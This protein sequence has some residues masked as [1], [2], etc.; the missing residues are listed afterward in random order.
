VR[1][2][3]S[4][5][6]LIGGT[7]IVLLRNVI[8]KL[9]GE[10]WAKCEFMNPSG[11]VKDRIA[12]YMIRNAEKKGLIKPGMKFL[13][14]TTGNTGIAFASVGAYLGYKVVIVI[15]E[16]MSSER[17]LTLKAL[18]AEIIY[19]P[20]GESDVLKSLEY[21]RNLSMEKPGEYYVFDQWSDEANISAH[22]ETTGREIVEQ[23]GSNIDAFIAGV[24]TGGTL[25]G[26]AKRLKEVNPK[27][28]I[29]GVEPSE[30][31]TISR[32]LWGT[33][34]IEGIGDGFTPEI[35]ERYKYL[36]DDWILVSSSEAISTAKRIA[37]MEGLFVGISSGANV[38]ASLM[39][40]R[41]HGLKRVVTI[42]PDYGSRYF[43]TKLVK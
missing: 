6:D 3:Y 37:C 28:K 5:L 12:L 26:V 41:D 33:H 32:G 8:E 21:A 25:I 30:C 38:A 22:Y 10:V 27:I 24:G 9:H 23:I 4:L 1:V 31:P 17:I 13:I 2:A 16:E 39:L 35:V 36:V 34:E 18:G 15:P 19:T 11:S 43:S 20:G 29:Y 14:P 7:P 42:L 40:L